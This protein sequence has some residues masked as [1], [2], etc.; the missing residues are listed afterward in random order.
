MYFQFIL[1]SHQNNNIYLQNSMTHEHPPPPIPAAQKEQYSIK[2]VL[3]K[4]P[5]WHK[6]IKHVKHNSRL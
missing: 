5:T 3:G 6:F 1:H 2:T 4:G